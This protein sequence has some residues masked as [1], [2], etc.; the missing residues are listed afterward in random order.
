MNRQSCEP[1]RPDHLPQPG[2]IIAD[3]Y[4]LER[5]AGTGASAVVFRA[6]DLHTGRRV[7]VKLWCARRPTHR[8]RSALEA[9]AL[10]AVDHP[11]VVGYLDHGVTAQDV[12][13][14]AMQWIEGETLSERLRGKGLRPS[15]C[16][17]L[18]WRI[19]SGLAALHERGIVHRDL[20]PSNILLAGDDPAAATIIDLGVARDEASQLG[21]T[22]DGAYVGT[23]RYMAPEQIRCPRDARGPSD[24]FAL[25]CILHEAIGGSPAYDANE[26][27]AILAQILFEPAPELRRENL[28]RQ[29]QQLIARMLCRNPK[30]R[31]SAAELLTNELPALLDGP[32]AKR[33]ARLGPPRVRAA[34]AS[35]EATAWS[36]VR[37]RG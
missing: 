20:K 32:T 27:F 13:Y 14:L 37:S 31:P 34:V 8:E 6:R 10:A 12:P 15:Q 4:E 26:M 21:L 7:A 1:A 5:L 35:G 9:Q 11:A 18:A 33:I 23:P 24:I 30:K 28:P 3:R 36:G 17:A 19:A 2:Q 25:G 22:A 16:L 29:L